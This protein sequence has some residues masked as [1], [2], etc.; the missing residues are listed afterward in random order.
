VFGS[1]VCDAHFPKCFWAPNNVIKY[2]GKTNLSVWVE[3]QCL[4]CRAG[5]VDDGEAWHDA[6]RCEHWG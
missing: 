3:D 1:N 2:D 6:A 5:G 4:E